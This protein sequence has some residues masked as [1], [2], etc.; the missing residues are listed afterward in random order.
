MRE[1]PQVP[2]EE[3]Q[4]TKKMEEQYAARDQEY[5]PE[6]R[7]ELSKKILQYWRGDAHTHSAESSREGWGYA[8]GIYSEAEAMRYYEGLGLEFVAFAEHT[9]KPGAPEQLAPD[10]PIAKSFLNQ[11]ER[12]GQLNR[13]SRFANIAG[14]SSAEA[15]VMFDANGQS[16][17]DLPPEVMQK[18]DMVIGSRHSIANEKDITA[19]KQSLMATINN[20]NIDAIGH[21]DRYIQLTQGV[22]DSDQP[23]SPEKYW[24]VWDEILEAM[25]KNG[26]AFEINFNNRPHDKLLELAAQKGVKFM[27][28][29]DAHD[30]GQYR[31]GQPDADNAKNQW[32][33]GEATADE[34]AILS[35]YKMDQLSGGPGVRA[36]AKLAHLVKKLEILGV[37]PDRII[38]SSRDRMLRFLTEERGKSTENLEFLKNKFN[39]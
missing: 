1:V 17:I 10:S 4:P 2:L 32:A 29:Y 19:I 14:L 38:D 23:C 34:L 24:Q 28:N 36:I 20:P 16:T 9:S 22:M 30:F 12:I 5:R 27:I 3:I 35:K 11:I 26:K 21:P 18:L 15:N 31:Q 37:T 25:A 33:K 7:T 13:D 6:G 8:E 39:K